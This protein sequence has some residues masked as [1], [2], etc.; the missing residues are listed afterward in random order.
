MSNNPTLIFIPGAWH[1][2]EIWAQVT[3]LLQEQNYKCI[4]VEL[5]STTGDATIGF[6]ED[7]TAVRNIILSETRQGHDVILIVHSYGG[8][9]GQSA[10]KG[11]THRLP[12]DLSSTDEKPTGHVVALVM[13]ACGFAQT[14]ISFIDAIGGTPPPLWRFDD[15]GFAILE[16]PARE[17][18]YHDLP[19][20][21]GNY[22]V[23]RLRKQS[24]KV[25]NEGGEWA[26]AGW[27]DLPVWYLMTMDDRTF[28]VEV[29]GAFVR[30]ARDAGADV[31]V[32]E[33]VSSHSPMLSRPEETV[34]FIVE[35]TGSLAR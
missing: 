23:S 29:Q 32:R 24:Q 28:P 6:G 12:D 8:A 27:M 15:S 13:M 5:P 7:I 22:W 9:V 33:V 1:R 35:A 19:V 10:V 14:G 4:P 18:F 31:T 16:L 17:A 26:Y 25:L 3:S 34:E 2:P 20:E 21:E 30:M 11:L